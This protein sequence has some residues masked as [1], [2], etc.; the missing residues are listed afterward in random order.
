MSNKNLKEEIIEIIEEAIITSVQGGI[1]KDM[2]TTRTDQILELIK[3][4]KE[5]MEDKK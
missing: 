3:N 1:I 2:A 4:K 5:K